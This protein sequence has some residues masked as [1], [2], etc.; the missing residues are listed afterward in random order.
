MVEELG[1]CPKLGGFSSK[2][3][4]PLKPTLNCIFDVGV[5]L[6]G[7]YFKMTFRASRD[8]VSTCSNQPSTDILC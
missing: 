2:G 5:C 4:P 6:M 3:F 8:L 7:R 1:L